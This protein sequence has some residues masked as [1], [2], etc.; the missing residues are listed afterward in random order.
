MGHMLINFVQDCN[1]A[2]KNDDQSWDLG[3]P[4]MF[5]QTQNWFD[6]HSE[7]AKPLRKEKNIPAMWLGLQTPG[8]TGICPS[9][10]QKL[11]LQQLQ[12]L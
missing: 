7:P 12:M 1:L 9:S 10:Q 4:Y 3:A 11:Q 6:H 8:Y 5:K 2:G